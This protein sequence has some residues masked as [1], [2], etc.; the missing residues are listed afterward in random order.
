MPLFKKINEPDFEISIWNIT[1]PLSFFESKFDW[2]PDIKNEKK[3]LEWFATRHLVNEMNGAFY[4]V[5]KEESG[6]PFLRSLPHHIS[7]TH[8]IDM[9]AVMQSKEHYVGVDLELIHPRIE[10]IAFKFLREDEINAIDP[11][12]KIEKLILYWSAKESLYKLYG[13][14][15][16]DFMTQL[17]IEPFDMKKKGEMKAEIV[18]PGRRAEFKLNNLKIGYEF[19]GE[20]VITYVVGR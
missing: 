5:V 18:V 6:K 3:K 16:I 20:H 19:F 12:E 14:R 13:L 2:H 10:R 8:T 7:I 1:E 17:L 15:E 11:K 4:E 9:A